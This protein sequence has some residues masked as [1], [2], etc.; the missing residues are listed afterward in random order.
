M[1]HRVFGRA[2]QVEN[3]LVFPFNEIFVRFS[4]R[5][6]T[7]MC[8]FCF[9]LVTLIFL[10]GTLF[11]VLFFSLFFLAPEM[12]IGPYYVSALQLI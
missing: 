6:I 2:M 11:D 4:L 1:L 12:G 8:L 7:N 5:Y 3:E 9:S 10:I